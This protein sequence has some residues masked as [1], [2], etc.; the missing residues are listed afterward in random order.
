MAKEK[1]TV[2]YVGTAEDTNGNIWIIPAG[3]KGNVLAVKE[4]K[5]RA[6][7]Y[8]PNQPS[9]W[10]YQQTEFARLTSLHLTNGFLNVESSSKTLIE[11]LDIHPLNPS[12]FKK[13]NLQ[14]DAENKLVNQEIVIDIKSKLLAKSKEKN[15][16]ILLGSLL[17]VKSRF[18]DAEK[19]SYLSPPE[20]R[21]ALYDLAEKSPGLFT[22]EDMTKVTCL[23]DPSFLKLDL[24]LRASAEGVIKPDLA[25]SKISWGNGEL[26]Q[27][28]TTGVEWKQF[29]VDYF[30]TDDGEKVMHKIAK[31]LE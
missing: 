18:F 31:D 22:N 1:L 4:G 20:I 24:I 10:I 28:V 13:I 25:G 23:T 26:I 12:K 14:E 5:E 3:N 6:I 27:D 8:S 16:S 2:Q 29:M 21:A 30:N 17:T 7:R 15:G 9:I 19:V 11:F